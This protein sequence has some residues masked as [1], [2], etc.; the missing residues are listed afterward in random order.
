MLIQ[1]ADFKNDKIKKRV[2]NIGHSLFY[3]EQTDS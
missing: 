1:Q 2:P 3:Y